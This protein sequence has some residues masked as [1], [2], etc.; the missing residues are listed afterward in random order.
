MLERQLALAQSAPD[1]KALVCV[2]LQGGNDGENTLIRYD[3]AGYQ[4][5]ASIRPVASG[6]NIPRASLL[7]IQPSN[8]GFPYGFHPACPALKTLFDGGKLAVIA[9][10]GALVEPVTRSALSG[11]TARL[12]GNLF[13]HSDQE[14][15]IQSADSTGVSHVG[16][17]GRIADRLDPY[18]PGSLFPP[19]ISTGGLHTFASGLASVPL[20]LPESGANLKLSTCCAES[21]LEEAALRLMM[22]RSRSNVYE[23]AVALYAQEGLSASSVLSPIFGPDTTP[24]SLVTQAFGNLSDHVAN[25]LRTIAQLIEQRQ[26]T[27]LKR[28][29]FYVHQFGYDTHGGQPGIQQQL[30]GDFSSGVGAF[31]SAMKALGLESN[32]TVFTLSDFGRTFNPA[33]NQGTDHGWGNYAFVAGGAV[34]GGRFYGTLPTLALDGPDDFSGAGRWIPTTSVEQYGAT[35]GRWF[36]MAEGDLPYVFP[37]IGA[38]PNTNLGFMG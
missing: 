21:A 23:A 6:I 25:Q 5:Y 2:Y 30:L 33:S 1:Y 19:L 13:S 15:A 38:F 3:T 18:N 28:Q 11:G 10:M 17:G 26:Q 16:W 24:S 14:L 7:P 37:N 22:A 35:L 34:K 20:I 31:C 4:N 32:V 27:G 9:N 8:V 29:V 12:P 36:G